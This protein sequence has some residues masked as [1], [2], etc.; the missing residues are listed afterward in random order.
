MFKVGPLPVPTPR[1]HFN[2]MLY[3]YIH[4]HRNTPIGT[5]KGLPLVQ[6]QGSLHSSTRPLITAHS[7][8]DISNGQ[9]QCTN[10]LPQHAQRFIQKSLYI[11]GQYQVRHPSSKSGR[12]LSISLVLL[13]SFSGSYLRHWPNQESLFPLLATSCNPC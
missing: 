4:A 3:R 12:C 11:A 7:H 10:F 1:Y 2:V 5:E 9:A 13:R 8:L 6:G